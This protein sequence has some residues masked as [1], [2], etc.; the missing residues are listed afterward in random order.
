MKKT[1]YIGGSILL[2]LIIVYM[3]IP[4]DVI[5]KAARKQI[6][7]IDGNYTVTY[8]QDSITKIY[9]IKSGKVTSTDKGYYFFWAETPNGKKYRQSPIDKTLI[10]E[11]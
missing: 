3:F 8:S 1:I 9:K 7:F 4:S 5:N 10:E 11:I 2:A 6:E